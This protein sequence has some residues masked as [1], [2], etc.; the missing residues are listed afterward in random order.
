MFLQFAAVCQMRACVRTLGEIYDACGRNDITS[1]LNA[2]KTIIFLQCR[3]S[4]AS[5]ELATAPFFARS[6]KVIPRFLI[7]VCNGSVRV[8]ALPMLMVAMLVAALSMM[9]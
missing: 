9:F 4:L 8:Y 2:G 1:A 7:T 6:C 5:C 3:C